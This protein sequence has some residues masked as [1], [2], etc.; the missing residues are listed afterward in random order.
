MKTFTS[1]VH[2][3]PDSDLLAEY[4]PFVIVNG[5]AYT[6]IVE[7][8]IKFGISPNRLSGRQSISLIHAFAHLDKRIKTYCVYGNIENS[9][10]SKLI[11]KPDLM[12]LQAEKNADGDALC[13]WN[14]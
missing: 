2:L 14:R 1:L 13:H 6:S 3:I 8:L 4:H 10:I 11:Y 12:S 5:T 7:L 9:I